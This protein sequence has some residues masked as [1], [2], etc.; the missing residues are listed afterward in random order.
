[1]SSRIW[2]RF[3][4]VC[5]EKNCEGQRNCEYTYNRHGIAPTGFVCAR[6]G[7]DKCAD[8]VMGNGCHGDCASVEED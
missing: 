2:N 5:T 7:L 4:N 3:C 6:R 1:M 8:C